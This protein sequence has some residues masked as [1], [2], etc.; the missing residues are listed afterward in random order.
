MIGRAPGVD[1]ALADPALEPHHGQ[2][3]VDEIGGVRFVQLTGRVAAR[4]DGEPIGAP[5]VVAVGQRIDLG[6][7][8]L[9]VEPGRRRVGGRRRAGTSRADR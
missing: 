7:S 1:V 4:V 9:R 8:R 3:D 2:L 6:T 5:T